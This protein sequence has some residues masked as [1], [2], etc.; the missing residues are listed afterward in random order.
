MSW[1]LTRISSSFSPSSFQPVEAE[2]FPVGEPFQIGIR[3]AEEFQLHLFELAGTEGKV[4]RCDLIS[5]GF[6]DLA[7]SE[8]NLLSRGALYIFKV[9]KDALRRLRSQINGILGILRHTPKRLEH[10][11]EL[12]DV[13]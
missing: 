13:L 1:S 2:L 10:Q 8:R 5:E 9:Y 12:A 6:S 4:A 3:L 11:V 7:D